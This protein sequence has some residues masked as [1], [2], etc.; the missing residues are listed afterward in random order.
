MKQL[1]APRLNQPEFIK[2]TYCTYP[3]GGCVEVARKGDF[4]V[5]RDAKDE[6]QKALVFTLPEWKA[7]ISGVKAGEFDFSMTF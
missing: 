7:F 6:N 3:P 4:I 1:N 2:S 5:V